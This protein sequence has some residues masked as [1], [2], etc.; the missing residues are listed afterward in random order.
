MGTSG[1]KVGEVMMCW[2]NKEDSKT[3]LGSLEA[4]REIETTVRS[5]LSRSLGVS[6]L[7]SRVLS[8]AFSWHVLRSSL[9]LWSY[10]GL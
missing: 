3:D 5:H 10:P 7:S 4:I 8:L 1:G 6:E 2:T 9:S